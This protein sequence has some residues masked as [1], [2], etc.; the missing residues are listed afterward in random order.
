MDNISQYV[1]ECYKSV[2]ELKTIYDVETIK[3]TEAET[4]V[5]QVFYNYFI[6]TCDINTIAIWEE[7]LDIVP[8]SSDT[9][10]T[11]RQK[12]IFKI[13]MSPPYTDTFLHKM[14]DKYSSGYNIEIDSVNCEITILIVENNTSL[15][16]FL[17]QLLIPIIP[18]HFDL[19][20]VIGNEYNIDKEQYIGCTTSIATIYDVGL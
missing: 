3:L 15:V 12:V 20:I 8:E 17:K 9:L 18:A 13:G 5:Y 2:R 6:Q 14:L 4:L 7:V 1:P 16:N 10:D 19:T 11:R